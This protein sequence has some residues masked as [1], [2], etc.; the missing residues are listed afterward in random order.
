MSSRLVA[1]LISCSAFAAERFTDQR[2]VDHVS[3]FEA[4]K[5]CKAVGLRLPTEAEW[6]YAARAGTT[7][8]RYGELEKVAWYER[9]SSRANPVAQKARNAFGLYDMLG[10]L[11]EWVSDRYDEKYYELQDGADP[12]GPSGPLQER[13]LR[14][15]ASR[16]SARNA[17]A[18]HRARNVP[19]FRNEYIGFRCAGEELP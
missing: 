8:P 11:F 4:D 9:N 7:G 15:G 19:A 1:L 18:S 6:E 13:I 3:W 17:R 14:G 2:P 5:Y 10:N 16:F 12:N